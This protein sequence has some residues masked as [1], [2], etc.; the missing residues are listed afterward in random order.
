MNAACSGGAGVGRCVRRTLSVASLFAPLSSSSVTT[1]ERSA[2]AAKCSGVLPSC[3]RTHS[4]W[5]MPWR[6]AR[7]S[8]PRYGKAYAADEGGG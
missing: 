7:V 4:A 5:Q 1:D 3:A 6:N 8:A 2:F